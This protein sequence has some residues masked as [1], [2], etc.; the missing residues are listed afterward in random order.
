MGLSVAEG[1][2]PATT[3]VTQD[4]LRDFSGTTGSVIQAATTGN[5]S[6]NVGRESQVFIAVM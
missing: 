6:D 5:G 3:V 1:S 4:G 2:S